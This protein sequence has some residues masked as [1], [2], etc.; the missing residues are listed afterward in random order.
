MIDKERI[1]TLIDE[2]IKEAQEE[3][4]WKAESALRCLKKELLKEQK[5]VPIKVCDEDGWI[6]YY[7]GN[8]ESFLMSDCYEIQQI[9][10]YPKYCSE[11]GMELNWNE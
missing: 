6:S 1:L 9:I 2:I 4:Q 11:C 5:T 3:P 8:C 10:T 7:C